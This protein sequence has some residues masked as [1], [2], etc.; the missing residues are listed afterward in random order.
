MIVGL[1]GGIGSGKSTVAKIFKKNTNVAVYIADDEAKELMNSSKIIKEKL[2]AHFGEK[3]Y[4][5]GQ[6]NRKYISDIV[7]DNKEKLKELNSIVHPEVKK[8]FQDF[9]KL[10]KDKLYVLYENAILFETEN[11]KF[12][13]FII[14]VNVDIETRIQRIIKRDGCSRNDV[15][16]RINNQWKEDKKLLQSHY[17]IYN[18]KM[19]NIN[20][21]VVRIHNILTKSRA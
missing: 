13:D 19:E 8:H 21:Q 20:I 7:F 1:T 18:N 15:L 10:N 3:S 4:L 16:N 9:L 17:L 14:S 11:N 6:L 12:C 5:N 2:I